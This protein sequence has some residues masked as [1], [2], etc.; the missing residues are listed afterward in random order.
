MAKYFPCPVCKGRGSWPG[1]YEHDSVDGVSFSV[2]IS[3][4]E[5][6]GYCN[7]DGMIEIGGEIHQRIKM[8]KLKNLMYD[9]FMKHDDTEY[10]SGGYIDVQMDKK[11]EEIKQLF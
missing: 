8:W 7:G 4:D 11:I 9:M 3:P 2:Q 1:E 10:L 5:E 6:C